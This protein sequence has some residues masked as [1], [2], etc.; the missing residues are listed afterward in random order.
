MAEHPNVALIRRGYA[1]FATGDL[2]TLDDLLAEDLVWHEP[3]RNLLS[4]DYRGRDSVFGLFGKVGEV[5]QGTFRLEVGEVYADDEHGIAVVT[6]STTR[7][8]R[9][10]E[11]THANLF[12]LRDGKVVEY[13]VVADDQD[14]ADELIG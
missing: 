1:A 2:A 10:V 3:G 6:V 4:G 5:T 12:R 14:A 7:D 11:H 13:W 8:G 9:F